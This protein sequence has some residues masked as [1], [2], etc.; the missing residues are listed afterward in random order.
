MNGG[1]MKKLH[2]TFQ[3]SEIFQCQT[4]IHGMENGFR[5]SMRGGEEGRKRTSMKTNSLFTEASLNHFIACSEFH[6]M[7]PHCFHDISNRTEMGICP[8]RLDDP[9]DKCDKNDSELF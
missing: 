5:Y 8:I 1:M 6:Q 9:L 2:V 4:N 3:C 7:A